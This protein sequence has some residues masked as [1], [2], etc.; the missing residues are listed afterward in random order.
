MGYVLGSKSLANMSPLHPN[1]IFVVKKAI[2]LTTVDF[3]VP[4]TGGGRTAQE[5]NV[6]FKQGVT[7]KDGFKKKSNHQIKAD[8]FGYAVDCVPWIDGAWEHED[9][10]PV[11]FVASAM[12]KAANILKTKIKWGGNWSEVMSTYGSDPDDM[13]AAVERYKVKH[14][15]PDFIDGPHFELIL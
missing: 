2:T 12:S 9:W 10:E 7:T 13:R 4:S 11:Y 14:A 1:L 8:G 3:G 6:L 15:G 5:Q